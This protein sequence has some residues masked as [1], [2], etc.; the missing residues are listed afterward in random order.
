MFVKETL[1]KFKLHIEMHTLIVE[2]SIPHSHQWTSH[3]DKKLIRKIMEQKYIM[4]QME[5]TDKENE[6]GTNP[7][8]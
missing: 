8:M 4:I 7:Q 1:L 6:N 2:T 3:P 5:I